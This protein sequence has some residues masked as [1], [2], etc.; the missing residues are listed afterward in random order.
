MKVLLRIAHGIDRLNDWMGRLTGWLAL[1]MILVGAYNTVARYLGSWFERD[2][3]S[4]AYI[5][6]QWYLFSLVFLLG[7][8][9]AFRVGAH[10]RVDLFYSK[11]SD[12]GRTWIDLVGNLLLLL[13]FCIFALWV[14]WPSV[15]NSWQVWEVSPDPDGLP[16]YPIKAMILVAF[17][18]LILQG[19][20]DT[21]KKIATLQGLRTARQVEQKGVL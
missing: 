1:L 10:V 9:H 19:L 12:R 15:R 21:V 11:L 13:P 4:N 5:E 18:L 3:S 20:A 16:R 8:A 17:I 14:S 7:A 2:L 6:M